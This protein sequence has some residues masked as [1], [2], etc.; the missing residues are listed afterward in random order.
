MS[1]P[2]V[3]RFLKATPSGGQAALAGFAA[4]VLLLSVL[5]LFT[6]PGSPLHVSGY[7]ITLGGKIMCY[8]IVAVAMDLIWGYAGI[9]SLGHGV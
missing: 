3:I 9:L 5:H 6:P 2:F 4:L 1:T 7:V 8:A